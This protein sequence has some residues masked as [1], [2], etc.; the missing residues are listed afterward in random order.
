M[1]FGGCSAIIQIV[2]EYHRILVPS[3]QSPKQD[4]YINLGERA[5]PTLLFVTTPGHQNQHT[6]AE[7]ERVR[8]RR[9]EEEER[10]EKAK[11]HV[12]ISVDLLGM[13][14]FRK[15]ANTNIISQS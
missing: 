10:G 8:C 15:E 12:Q 11:R 7:K 13:K 6:M 9:A 2:Q 1:N 5:F 3:A 4:Q 14:G